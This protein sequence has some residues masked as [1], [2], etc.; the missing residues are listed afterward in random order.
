MTDFSHYVMSNVV[1]Y[2]SIIV[3]SNF[4]Q[5]AM[6]INQ[7]HKCILHKAFTQKHL[8]EYYI[9]TSKSVFAK[10]VWHSQ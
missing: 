9:Y 6:L 2:S 8:K 5:C 10:L 7:I 1:T 4:Q 3:A